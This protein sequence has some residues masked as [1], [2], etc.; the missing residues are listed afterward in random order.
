MR[1][2]RKVASLAIGQRSEQ[3]EV[4]LEAQK[5][6]VEPLYSDR[7]RGSRENNS[8]VGVETAPRGHESRESRAVRTW[9]RL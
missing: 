2:S 1:E 3:R 7:T 8:T 9:Q 6:L 4:I 5:V